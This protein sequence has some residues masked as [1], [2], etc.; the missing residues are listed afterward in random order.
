MFRQGNVF[1]S[2]IKR[3]EIVGINM[4]PCPEWIYVLVG[5]MMAGVKAVGLAFTYTDGSDLVAMMAKLRTCSLLV[6]DPGANEENWQVFHRLLDAYSDTGR[7]RSSKMPYLRYFLGHKF[8]DSIT[9]VRALTSCLEEKHDDVELPEINAP[10]I[11]FLFQTSGST[12]VPKLV[13][14]THASMTAVGRMRGAKW[15]Q[16]ET[17]LFNDRPFQWIGGF[18]MNLVTGSTRVC[19]SGWAI[20]EEDKVAT[21]IDI[22]AREQCNLALALPP[23]MHAMMKHKVRIVLMSY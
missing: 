5:C 15:F 21:N 16:S 12:G 19:K 10:D 18:P 17:I 14:H 6:L 20:F 4:R 2:G 13:A 11:A 9:Q 7:V 22:I 8:P 1:I 3:D 23:M